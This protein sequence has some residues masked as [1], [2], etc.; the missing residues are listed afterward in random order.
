MTRLYTHPASRNH[1]T[2]QG[3]PEQVARIVAIEN[4]LADPAFDAL[5][6]VAAPLVSDDILLRVHPQSHLDRIAAASP[7][8][9]MAQLDADTWLSPG[10]HEAARRA[11]GAAAD[12][13]DHVMATGGN[14]FCAMRPPGHHAEKTTPMGFCLFGSVA[15]AARHA[16]DHH[17]LSRVAVVDFDVH[18]GNGTQDLLWHEDR[19]LFVSSHQM[20]LY[21]GSGYASETGAS[22]NILNLPLDGGS[23]GTEMRAAYEAEVFP[24]LEAY[25]P[26]LLLVSAGFDAHAADPLAGLNWVEEDFIWITE[27]LCDIA[28][29]HCAG[30]LVSCLEGGY[31]LDALASSVAAHVAVLMKRDTA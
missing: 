17:G 9:G 22:G 1:V 3:H 28:D 18:H 16:L 26:E 14:A 6:R 10:S 4:A 21:P 31:D 2:P 24:A 25:K 30:R 15:A 23:D 13:V 7:A 8:D 27:R 29:T 11:A 5:D 19:V 20:P 12:A